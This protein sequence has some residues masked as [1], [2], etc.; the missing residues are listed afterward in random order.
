MI[1]RRR[2]LKLETY[3]LSR[4]YKKLSRFSHSAREILLW[5]CTLLRSASRIWEANLSLSS[6]W[7]HRIWVRTSTESS[8]ESRISWS[9]WDSE[10]STSSSSSSNS[11]FIEAKAMKDKDCSE[12]RCNWI[13]SR[14]MI[15]HCR[16]MILSSKTRFCKSSWILRSKTWNFSNVWCWCKWREFWVFFFLERSSDRRVKTS[17]LSSTFSEW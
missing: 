10:S 1:H 14:A 15:L 2:R 9:N 13:K 11:K 7:F 8:S 5:Y 3:F 16:S 17:D 6:T 12:T 4:K